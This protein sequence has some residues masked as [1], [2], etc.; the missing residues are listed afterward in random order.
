MTDE[1]L[2]IPIDSATGAALPD[3]LRMEL[4]DPADEG[5]TEAWIRAVS[6]GF[7]ESAPTPE[8]L[9]EVLDDRRSHRM[10]AVRDE[11]LAEP[12]V[13]VGTV[14]GLPLRLTV[15]GGAVETWGI[16][17]VTVAPTHRRRG[18]AR[19]LLEE[20]L[21]TTAAA[22]LATAALTVSE[23]TIYGRFG[24]APAAWIVDLVI[25]AKRARW[26][27]PTP[28]GRVQFV[29]RDRIL[30]DATGVLD[31]SWLQSPG[32]VA[33]SGL[34][35]TGL[36][37]RPSAQEEVRKRR[38]VRYDDAG[39]RPQGFAV[40]RIK[41]NPDDFSRA[42][43][44]V[45][46]LTAVTDDAYAALWRHVLEVDLVAE[47][48]AHLRPVDEPLRWMVADQRAIRATMREHLWLRVVDPVAALGARRYA[49]PGRLVL[50]VSDP[51]GFAE[52]AV[53]VEA[54]AHGAATVTAPAGQRPV[55]APVLA[56]DAAALAALYLGGTAA[57]T[58]LRAGRVVERT[59][60]AAAAA[61]RLLSSAATPWL[62]IWF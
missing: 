23:A 12:E 42:T 18:V 22:G 46:H 48:R 53:L 9:A 34:L 26:I 2:R 19:A 51:L 29:S 20:Q 24:F 33:V 45:L 52:G 59:P 58:L 47:V 57:A 30:E 55:D 61:D 43:L 41:D 28:S 44:E 1:R 56:L 4:V 40:Y 38:I 17:E 11:T 14:A 37:G 25:D 49:A 54:D 8:E 60:G 31:R 39:G 35:M 13:P 21:R 62:S 5:A 15:P 50:E 16:T 32:E 3:G 36:F 27:A 10:V 7:H 6:R